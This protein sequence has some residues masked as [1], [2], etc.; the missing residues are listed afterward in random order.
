[1]LAG[2]NLLAIL[3]LGLQPPAARADP[4]AEGAG[5]YGSGTTTYSNPVAKSNATTAS[6]GPGGAPA[7]PANHRPFQ[8]ARQ[9]SGGTLPSS[10]PPPPPV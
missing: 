8:T 7:E 6:A 5:P 1:M 2:F 9:N 4:E 3:F 10:A